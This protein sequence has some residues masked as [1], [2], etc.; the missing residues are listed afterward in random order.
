MRGAT[1]G[2]AGERLTLRRRRVGGTFRIHPANPATRRPIVQIRPTIFAL[3]APFVAL[4]P[5]SAAASGPV[6]RPRAVL[7]TSEGPIVLELFADLCPETVARFLARNHAGLQLCQS[8]AGGWQTFGCVPFDPRGPE[9]PQAPGKEPLLL[10]EIDA[11]AMGLDARR[12]DDPESAHDLWQ[13]Q[14]LPRYVDL[15][16][17]GRPIPAGLQRLADLFA[18]KGP[19]AEAELDGRSRLWLLEQLGFVFRR[20]A[21]PLPVTRGAVATPTLWPGEADERFMIALATVPEFDGRAT[22][23]GRVVE[24][25][26]TLAKIERIPTDHRRRT[27]RPVFTLGLEKTE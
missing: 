3:L 26:E 5:V 23:F 25:W 24:G 9:R 11:R 17:H 20:G 10:P 4:G 21:S 1:D 2:A 16:Q 19:A 15:K 18:A 22:V 13:Q 7:R 27:E 12:A 8:W 6:D 14:I